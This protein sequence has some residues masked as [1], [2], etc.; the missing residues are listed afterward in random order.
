MAGGK[1]TTYRLMGEQT[2][3]QI[4]SGYMGYKGYMG[5]MSMG[6]RASCRTAQEPLL[7]VGGDGRGERDSAAANSAGGPWS[8]TSAR[9]WAV[10]L[11][12]VMVRRTSWH[13]YFVTPRPRRRGWPIGWASCWV[14]PEETRGAELERY[15]RMTGRQTEASSPATV[16][17]VSA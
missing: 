16:R 11:D 14:G 7:P 4:I 3:D 8:T 2:V 6:R 13:Y 9:E 1:L 5:Y 10:H 17:A 12:D 15:A